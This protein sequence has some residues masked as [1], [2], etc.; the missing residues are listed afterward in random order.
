MKFYIVAKKRLY[1][2]FSLFVNLYFCYPFCFNHFTKKFMKSKFLKK[3]V[4]STFCFTNNQYVFAKMS[5]INW[6]IS[7]FDLLLVLLSILN[8]LSAAI[9]VSLIDIVVEAE[10]ILTLILL[11]FHINGQRSFHVLKIQIFFLECWCEVVANIF[12][13]LL[14][15]YLIKNVQ[16]EETLFRHENDT[17]II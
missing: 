11:I 16:M 14:Y 7:S 1:F 17:F 5:I 2:S 15:F 4:F 3:I 9:L 12:L 6:L 8:F 10:H 13:F